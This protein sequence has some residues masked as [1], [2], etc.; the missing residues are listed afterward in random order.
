VPAVGLL[1]TGFKV[2]L[3]L[4]YNGCVAKIEEETR[5]DSDGGI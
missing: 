4:I 1:I 5:S 2:F 3:E